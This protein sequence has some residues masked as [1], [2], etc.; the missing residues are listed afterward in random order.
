MQNKNTIIW[1]EHVL[2]YNKVKYII[3]AGKTDKKYIHY[4]LKSGK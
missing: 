3:P 1:N 2:M 4:K